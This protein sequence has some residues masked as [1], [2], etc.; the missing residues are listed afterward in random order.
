MA[1]DFKDF[2][3]MKWRNQILL[4]AGVCGGLLALVWYQFLTPINEEITAKKAELSQLQTEIG[5][6]QQQ[7]KRY[8]QFKAEAL[9]LANELETL[10]TVLPL[11][12]ENDSLLRSVQD[13]ITASGLKI[14]RFLPRPPIDREVYL[15]WPI[16][17]E[18]VGTYH[19]IG[20]Y[21]DRVR[22]LPRIVN[23]SNLKINSRAS[24]GIAASTSS[25]GATLVATTF[26]YREE[27]EEAAKTPAN[28]PAQKK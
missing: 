21:L 6:A 17:M 26:I 14:L 1:I 11:E 13:M 9:A 12:K 27:E 10:K 25:V 16:D 5:K 19:N 15:E 24:T 8:A 2:A 23:I 28:T 3:K 18:I 22:R 20:A 7:Q 4:V